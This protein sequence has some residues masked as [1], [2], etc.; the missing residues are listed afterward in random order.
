MAVPSNHL[1]RHS[2]IHDVPDSH[3]ADV[4]VFDDVAVDHSHPGV[5]HDRQPGL[6][7]RLQC[8]VVANALALRA[9]S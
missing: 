9:M 6:V 4:L 2:H 3:H 8:D 7:V 5:V 1:H